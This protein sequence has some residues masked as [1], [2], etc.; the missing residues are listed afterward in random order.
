MAELSKNEQI[1]ARLAAI[2]AAKN[3]QVEPVESVSSATSE[4][5]TLVPIPASGLI[6]NHTSVTTNETI[7]K[8]QIIPVSKSNQVQTNSPKIIQATPT[9][10]VTGTESSGP[11]NVFKMKLAELE[12]KLLAEDKDYPFLLRDIH[13]TMRE[14]PNVVTVLTD[15]EIGLIVSGLSKH[16]GTTITPAKSGSGRSKS[17]RTQPINADDL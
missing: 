14:D 11:Y 7:Q 16:V 6:T 10:V 17:G 5:H 1:K 12:Q 4:P 13:I 8:N 2:R 3:K 15:E 9:S